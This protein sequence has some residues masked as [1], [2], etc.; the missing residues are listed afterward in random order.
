MDQDAVTRFGF[1]ILPMTAL[2]SNRSAKRW[3]DS[4]TSLLSIIGGAF[5]VVSLL[6]RG[7]GGARRLGRLTG[8]R[9]G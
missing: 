7:G 9:V 6:E 4:V 5:T 1:D 8:A 3:Y 2:V